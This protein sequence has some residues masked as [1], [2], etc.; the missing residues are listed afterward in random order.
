[1]IDAGSIPL[2]R[3]RQSFRRPDLLVVPGL[4]YRRW[5]GRRE[6]ARADP[7][8]WRDLGITSAQARDE[9]AKPFWKS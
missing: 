4:W 9:A 5:R 1:M 7:A 2:R 3:W 6:L 8:V